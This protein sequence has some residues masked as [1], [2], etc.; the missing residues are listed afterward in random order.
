[1]N[2]NLFL[3]LL[4]CF[5]N[6]I[7]AQTEEKETEEITEEVEMEPAYYGVRHPFDVPSKIAYEKRPEKKVKE[8]F[9]D[10][11]FE[12]LSERNSFEGRNIALNPPPAPRPFQ[13]GKK[14]G[15]V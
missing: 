4:L 2:K 6:F 3:I 13:D 15:S 12:Y 8:H 10:A 1:M 9:R 14:Y 5:S 11:Y 7:F